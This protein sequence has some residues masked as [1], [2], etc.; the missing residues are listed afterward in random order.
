MGIHDRDYYRREGPSY[1]E[2][3]IPSGVVCKWLIF[4]NVAVFLLQLATRS[5]GS[6]TDALSLDTDK[7][8]HS[9]QIWRLITH[10]FLHSET[11]WTHIVFNM[12]FLWM[13]GSELETLLG[14]KEF[15]AFYLAAALAG[16]LAFLL[17]AVIAQQHMVGLGASGAVTGLLV[18]AAFH[19]PRMVIQL[20]GIIPMPIWFFVLFQVIQ[21]SFDLFGLWPADRH[22]A[23]AAHL[24]GAAF[25]AL[26]FKLH[27]RILGLRRGLSS[28]L[29]ARRRPRL[30]LY[31]PEEEQEPVSVAA[32][33]A[34]ALDEH[35]EAKLD[36]LLEKVARHGKD[37]LTDK[38][39]E[40]L[41]RAS[42]IYKKRRT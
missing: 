10:A 25:A 16:G 22:V 37:S 31:R 17:H 8:I 21:D 29:K 28:W 5:T 36:A 24:G 4:L 19:F 6:V 39:N 12:F 33:S 3:L 23:V 42:E 34:P 1:L 26:Y 32:A 30:R 14:W 41:L 38:E 27:W 18:L 15:L 9:G 35:L 11:I 7:V 2:K 40:I 20:F 13:F